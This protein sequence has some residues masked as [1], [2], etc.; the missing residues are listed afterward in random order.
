M[1]FL[2]T[3]LLT[4]IFIVPT[5]A[6]A[7]TIDLPQLESGKITFNLTHRGDQIGT[8][9]VIIKKSDDQIVVTHQ[10]DVIYTA[11]FIKLYEMHHT[12]QEVWSTTN[13]KDVTLVRFASNTEE[14]GNHYHVRGEL[15]DA[16]FRVEGPLGIAVAT[17]DVT[18]TNSLWS[19]YWAKR[20]AAYPA[21][22]DCIDGSLMAT[23]IESA[24]TENINGQKA[25]KYV[26]RTDL[27]KA[28]S[29]FLNSYLL[30]AVFRRGGFQ[31]TYQRD[32]LA[33]N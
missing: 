18:T 19:D 11:A 2:L 24:G 10:L 13:T 3:C 15:D 7:S 16:G 4:A 9:T 28:D 31:V 17:S 1:K 5:L 30:T 25:N 12:S 33:L 27:S 23:A 21:M 29:W 14:N 20:T 8:H 6:Q 26:I 22:L 32:A